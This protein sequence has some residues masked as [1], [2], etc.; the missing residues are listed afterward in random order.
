MKTT[1]LKDL[2][3]SLIEAVEDEEVVIID[4]GCGEVLEMIESCGVA[5]VDNFAVEY[6]EKALKIANE[7]GWKIIEVNNCKAVKL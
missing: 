3:N 6:E 7:K 1:L 4:S 5:D 2:I